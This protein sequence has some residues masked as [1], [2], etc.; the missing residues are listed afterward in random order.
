MGKLGRRGYR[1]NPLAH[2][3]LERKP[4]EPPRPAWIARVELGVVIVASLIFWA[5]VV[6]Y[7][8]ATIRPLTTTKVAS[9]PATERTDR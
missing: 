9:Y 1:I 3:W 8:W 7:V 4:L 2:L 5:M 6:I